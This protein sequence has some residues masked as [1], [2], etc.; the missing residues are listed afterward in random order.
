MG[1]EHKLHLETLT[2]FTF[3]IADSFAIGMITTKLSSNRWQRFVF[4]VYKNKILAIHNKII[5]YRCKD[6]VMIL[7]SI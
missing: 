1:V 5:S 6:L 7:V 2:V 4:Y 3:I